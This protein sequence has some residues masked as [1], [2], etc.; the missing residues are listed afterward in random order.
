MIMDN[1]FH[2]DINDD[3]V[4]YF[5]TDLHC[6]MIRLNDLLV[7]LG[8][9][10]SERSGKRLLRDIDLLREVINEEI[11][12][13]SKLIDYRLLTEPETKL[14]KEINKLRKTERIKRF[15][16]ITTG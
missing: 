1:L 8:K 13:L 2:T 10:T 15:E 5:I 3:F 14:V 6:N 11:E 7:A 12:M 9:E 16:K 4:E